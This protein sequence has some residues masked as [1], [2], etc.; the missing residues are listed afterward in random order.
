MTRTTLPEVNV[1]AS[2]DVGLVKSARDEP[3]T[4]KVAMRK[5]LKMKAAARSVVARVIS[6]PQSAQLPL[7]VLFAYP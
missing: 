1:L 5:P 6:I 2:F 3:I 4:I 7:S